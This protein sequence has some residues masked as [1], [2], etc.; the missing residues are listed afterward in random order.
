MTSTVAQLVQDNLTVLR[1][2][3]DLVRVLDEGAYAQNAPSLALSGVGPHLR[4]VVDFYQRFLTAL[5]TAPDD[6]GPYSIRIDYDARDRDPRVETDPVHALSVLERTIGRLR[7][8][9]DHSAARAG[10]TL[11]VRSDGSPWID[12]TVARELQSL[13]SHTVHH[14]ALIAI[15]VRSQGGAP[16]P[17]FGVAPSTLRHWSEQKAREG[18]A[19]DACAR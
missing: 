5:E 8:V 13:V 1:Q 9:P 14:Y 17:E 3:H 10:T 4:H 2:G 7:A 18:A 6:A 11:Q 16:D 12:S 19:D 15:A